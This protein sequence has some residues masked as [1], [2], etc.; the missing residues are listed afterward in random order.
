LRDLDHG[1]IKTRIRIRS[2][3]PG[4]ANTRTTA[5]KIQRGS[6]LVG[7]VKQRG[8]GHLATTTGC[9]VTR[10]SYVRRGDMTV[11]FL[12]NLAGHPELVLGAA[13]PPGANAAARVWYLDVVPHLH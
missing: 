12:M 4:Q 13:V 9:W 3:Q 8:T 1:A 5:V 11:A 7:T 10:E 6:L 2:N